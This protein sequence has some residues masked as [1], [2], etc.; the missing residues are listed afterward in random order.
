MTSWFPSKKCINCGVIVDYSER[1]QFTVGRYGRTIFACSEKCW[2][3]YQ[4]LWWNADLC[5]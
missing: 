3:E 2:D 5:S 4:Y 1:L